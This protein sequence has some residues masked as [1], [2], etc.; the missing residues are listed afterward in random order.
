MN[1]SYSIKSGWAALAVLSCQLAPLFGQALGSA[2]TQVNLSRDQAAKID[3]QNLLKSDNAQGALEALRAGLIKGAGA[4]SPDVQVVTALC[5]VARALAAEQHPAA[6]NAALLAAA[7]GETAKAKA[8]PADRAYLAAK[9]GELYESTVGD[10]T[11]ARQQYQLALTIDARRKDAVD[12]LRRLA[13]VDALLQAKAQENAL[14]RQA[15]K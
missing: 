6:A 14:L 11:A 5:G 12:G 10:R 7:E 15:G 3:A 8:P 1:R 9:L 2:T 13:R 4:P